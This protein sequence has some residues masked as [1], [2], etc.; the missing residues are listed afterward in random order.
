MV[1]RNI[2]LVIGISVLLAYIGIGVF[3]L[4]KLNH[5]TEVPMTN[6]PYA[7]NGFSV[8]K[9][10]FDHINSWHQFSNAIFPSVLSFSLLAF[11]MILYFFDKQN[12][13]NQK[14]YFYKWKYY[15]DNKKLYSF[16]DKIIKWLSLF[17][18]SPSFSHVRHS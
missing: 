15:L 7:E 13:L 9:D 1:L 16:F 17:E 14:Q 3:G 2:K 6:C 12:F 4:F 18:N 5:M 8:C 11:G 10:N